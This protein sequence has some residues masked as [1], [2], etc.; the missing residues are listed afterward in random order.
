[1]TDIYYNTMI[2]CVNYEIIEKYILFRSYISQAL[3]IV[4]VRSSLE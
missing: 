2:E 3:E 4:D 1:M